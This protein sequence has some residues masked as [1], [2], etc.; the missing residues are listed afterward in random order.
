ML[1][2]FVDADRDELIA[3]TKSKVAK[4]S[5]PGP[6]RASL[7]H[8]VPLFLTQL[9]QILSAVLNAEPS[10][11]SDAMAAEAALHGHEMLRQ[12]FTIAQVVHDYG[13]VCQAITELAADSNTQI[14]A[15][16]FHTL[17]LCLDNAIA[18]AVTEISAAA[19]TITLEPRDRAA[20][21]VGARATKSHLSGD[22]VVRDVALWHR[23]HRG[24]DR[25]GARP[26]AHESTRPHRRRPCRSPARD[27]LAHR[28]ARP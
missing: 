26:G 13:D 12:G 24:K 2:E 20:G 7:E 1:S 19:R 5:A 3:R 25:L 23:A 18:G 16:E 9:T 14:G 22:A 4:R 17:N 10:A 6:D 11:A 15:G 21:R 28:S 27:G 8:G